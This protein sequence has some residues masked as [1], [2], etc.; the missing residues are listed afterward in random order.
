MDYYRIRKTWNNGKWDKT[1]KG[2]YVSRVEAINA[3]T[4]ELINEGYMVFDPNGV[5]IYPIY[6]NEI[7]KILESDGITTDVQYW[8]NVFDKKE[9]VNLSYVE[10]IIKRYHEKLNNKNDEIIKNDNYI[11][12]HNGL[13]IYKIPGHSF[14]VKYLDNKKT[15]SDENTYANAGYF[16][17]FEGNGVYFT[18][19]VANVVC[20]IDLNAVYHIAA[21]YLKER[22]IVNNKLYFAA[23]QNASSEFRNKTVSTICIKN[24]IIECKKLNHYNE[25]KQYDYA[26][27]GVPIISHGVNQTLK[28]IT[29]QGWDSGTLR[30]TM[31]GFLGLKL[32][33]NNN[34]Y[35]FCYQTT[36]SGS[37]G[38]KEI[39]EVVNGIGFQYLLKLD[40]GGSAYFKYEN[41][42]I[43]NTSENRHINT[44]ITF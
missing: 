18:L 22:P 14:K 21:T 12:K 30:A 5:V 36:K 34:L 4:E 13:T 29:D 43:M 9:E 20:D 26:I 19:P 3:C 28:N 10:T 7:A 42:E 25:L 39:Q 32:N 41:K 27:S 15:S 35:Y 31:H 40:G 6:Y 23:N 16:A 8:S 2:A 1:Q 33:D 38:L 17:G 44:I 24:N 11:I 37:N